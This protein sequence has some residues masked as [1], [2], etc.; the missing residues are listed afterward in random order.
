MDISIVI[1]KST[2][3]S[4]SFDELF[5]LSCYYK[6]I[7]TPVLT[8]EILGDLKKE[9]QEGKAPPEDRVK[10]FAKKLFPMETVVNL[11][12]KVLLKGDLLGNP[13]S[14][15]GRPH[16]GIKKAVASESGMRGY[17]IEETEEEKSI[18]KWKDGNFS[19]ADHELSALWRMTTT[20][21]DLLERLKKSL[22]PD[23]AIKFVDFHELNKFVSESIT[24]PATQQFLLISLLQN[25]D[26]DA[27]SSVQ[28]F[29]RWNQEG[30]PLI[31][32]FAP[33]AFH[34][35]K[36]DTLFLFGLTSGLIGTRPTNRVDLEY[37]YYLPF[38]NIFTSND[39]VHKNLVPLL[40][41]ADQ[42]FITGPEL[43]EDLKN[44][45]AYL[46]TL[47]I[48]ER[49]KFKNVPPIIDSSI[50]FQ[51]WKEFFNYPQ[52]SNWNRDISEAEK[53]KMKEKMKEFER[54]LDGESINL[55]SGEDAEFVIKKSWLSKTDPCFCGSG[56]KVIDCCIPEPKF[57]ELGLQELRKQIKNEIKASYSKADH[58]RFLH[59]VGNALPAIVFAYL[60]NNLDSKGH[61]GLIRSFKNEDLK[62]IG[63]LKENMITL[64]FVEIE[65]G[66]IIE[67][68]PLPC[69][70]RQLENFLKNKYNRISILWG[71][72]HP[73]NGKDLIIP[74]PDDGS[75]PSQI[76]IK[77]FELT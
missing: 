22:N 43:K 69:N 45:V 23:A 8:M 1:D 54:A 30:K 55:E 65:T 17:L 24:S 21:E 58:V 44:I 31:K 2:F 39:K 57:N 9:A 16:V 38:G 49:R 7:I 19:E 14:F 32:D 74:I 10:D 62:L 50:T 41:Q 27:M 56:K 47:E 52:K 67:L 36:V 20:Q 26:I 28:I 70:P 37:L 34:C 73:E 48:E 76:I 77:G 64:S 18:Y 66:E 40:L 6:H 35:L 25:Y 51:L 63:S 60:K 13:I 68:N 11:H 46:N 15:D 71:L 42:R 12:Y 59:P 75:P 53:E 72:V 29:G 3:Q 5:R 33:F 4:L 61:I